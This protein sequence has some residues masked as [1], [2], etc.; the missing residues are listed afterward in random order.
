[1]KTLISVCLSRP[2]SVAAFFIL[3]MVLAAVAYVRLPVSL[4][5]DLRYPGLVVW[6]SYPDVPPDRVERAVTERVEQAVAG[7][8]G[9]TRVTSRTLLGGSLVHMQFGWNA[10]LNLA[11]LDVRENMDRLGDA[12]PRE[13]T[14]PAV[15][16]LDPGERPIMVIALRYS[17]EQDAGRPE[18]LMELKRMGRDIIARRLEQL[19]DVARVQVTGG[20]ERRIEIETD[21]RGCGRHRPVGM[22]PVDEDVFV[23]HGGAQR[24]RVDRAV[25]RQYPASEVGNLFRGLLGP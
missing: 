11:L 3:L 15:L 16:H 1:M 19:T 10:N 14:R 12:F 7:T 4:L 8:A 25:D 13:A 17:G 23:H 18:D 24:I 2:V 21:P 6:T 22:V 9:L 5:P 20:F